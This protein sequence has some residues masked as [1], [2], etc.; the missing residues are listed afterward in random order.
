MMTCEKHPD[1][2]LFFS[3]CNVSCE[4]L[5][6]EYGRPLSFNENTRAVEVT[7]EQ[8]CA[9]CRYELENNLPASQNV[10]MTNVSDTMQNVAESLRV[11]GLSVDLSDEG[12]RLALSN[13]VDVLNQSA[14]ECIEE[15]AYMQRLGRDY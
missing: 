8:Q 4:M 3:R 11:F 7:G 13:M 15:D 14:K 2:R 9:C 6:T 10:Q 5:M 1:N 12:H